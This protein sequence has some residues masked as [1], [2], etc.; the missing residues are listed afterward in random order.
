M[1]AQK[2]Y[3]LLLLQ[4]HQQSQLSKNKKKKKE[5]SM[6]ILVPAS[7]EDWPEPLPLK[8]P[9]LLRNLSGNALPPDCPPGS[10]MN[11]LMPPQPRPVR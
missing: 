11:V 7:G 10:P 2:I 9:K 4:W 1:K 5:K 3:I 8:L 6:N